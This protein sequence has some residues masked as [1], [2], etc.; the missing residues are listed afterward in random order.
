MASMVVIRCPVTGEEIP[1][2]ILMDL[3]SLQWLP[4]EEVELNCPACGQQHAWS[5]ST[6]YLSLRATLPPRRVRTTT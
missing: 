5:R 6:A 4:E 1:T 2:G 3:H